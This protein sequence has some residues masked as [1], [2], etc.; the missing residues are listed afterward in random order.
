MN[1][2]ETLCVNGNAS[3]WLPFAPSPACSRTSA[4]SGRLYRMSQDERSI[5]REI[6]VSV[7]IS[8]TCICTCVLFRTVSE[9]EL[10][11]GTVPKLLVRKI[12]PT[13]SNTGVYC[14]SDKVGTIY[15][16]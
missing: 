13:V 6:I 10:F 1:S 11:H 5:F 12:L 9:I 4:G 14:S 3:R 7:I 2:C 15:L 16:V 8:R